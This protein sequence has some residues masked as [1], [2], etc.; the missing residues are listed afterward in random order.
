MKFIA[1]KPVSLF[2]QTVIVIVLNFLA[3]YRI[4]KS[5]RYLAIILIPTV[6][7]ATITPLIFTDIACLEDGQ[8]MLI[9]YNSCLSYEIN[10]ILQAIYGGFMVFSIYL[11]RK[12]SRE[13]NKQYEV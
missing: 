11:I 9:R 5:K 7:I 10:I 2:W 1:T 12:W 6:I 13:W 4:Q 8:L 3:A